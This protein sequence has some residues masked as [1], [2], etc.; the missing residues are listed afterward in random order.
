MPKCTDAVL[1]RGSEVLG[2]A[3]APTTANILDGIQA[4]VAKA[5]QA[6]SLRKYFLVAVI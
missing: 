5:L 6:A 3:K 1:L 4:A 2:L